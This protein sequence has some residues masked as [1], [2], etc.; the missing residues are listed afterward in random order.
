MIYDLAGSALMNWLLGGRARPRCEVCNRVVRRSHVTALHAHTLCK[1]CATAA[2]GAYTFA[3]YC[4]DTKP[5]ELDQMRLAI[6]VIDCLRREC[7]QH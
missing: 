7:K 5:N 6:A 1:R 4:S 3:V 2:L